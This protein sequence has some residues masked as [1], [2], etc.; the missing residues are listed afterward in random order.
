MCLVVQPSQRQTY[1]L[2]L[3]GEAWC[4]DWRQVR[5]WRDICG[6]YLPT[7]EILSRHKAMLCNPNLQP[8]KKKNLPGISRAARP[9]I[10][11]MQPA[12]RRIRAWFGRLGG[13][14]HGGRLHG[15]R[16]H[17]ARGRRIGRK[18]TNE[19]TRLRRWGCNGQL[20]EAQL[21]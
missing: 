15:K 4:W 8:G 7:L 1:S 10:G 3:L 16:L 13:G 6:E 9:Q 14:I 18:L 12:E 19:A 5:L 11:I 20:Q 17:D 2:P 21:R